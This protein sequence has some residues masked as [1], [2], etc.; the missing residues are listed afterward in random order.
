MRGGAMVPKPDP[1]P[2]DQRTERL[3]ACIQCALN[4]DLP[5]QLVALQGL[6]QL[7]EAEEKGRLGSEGMDFLLRLGASARRTL[8][9]VVIL[10]D[11]HKLTTVPLNMER[12]SL[13]ALAQ[14]LVNE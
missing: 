4:H 11:L 13:D 2:A 7:L 5:N 12:V 1:A 8:D 6:V 9:T 14:A 3:L 10:R